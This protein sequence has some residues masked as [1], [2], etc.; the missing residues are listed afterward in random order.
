[1]N[2][3]LKQYKEAVLFYIAPLFSINT[4]DQ[5]Q[6][7]QCVEWLDSFKE[8]LTNYNAENYFN[9][10]YAY[11][12]QL[13]ARYSEAVS[14]QMTLWIA[15]IYNRYDDPILNEYNNYVTPKPDD[16]FAILSNQIEVVNERLHGQSLLTVVQA[17]MQVFAPFQQHIIE[18]L[19]NNP[20]DFLEELCST[21]N[22]AFN[23]QEKFEDI[24][25]NIPDLNEKDMLEMSNAVSDVVA[26]YVKVGQYASDLLVNLIMSDIQPHLDEYL[27]QQAWMEGSVDPLGNAIETIND[28]LGDLKEWISCPYYVGYI[29]KECFLKLV[30]IIFVL[31]YTF[32]LLVILLYLRSAK[33]G[34]NKR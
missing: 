30:Y 4:L 23:L 14:E 21:V 27:F 11:R 6:V 2:L 13:M 24:P 20:T 31:F 34:M 28:Y 26:E 22:D 16:T 9:E 19:K 17:C 8:E 15:N 1:M 25:Y 7:L 18:E 29:V 10:F 33:D 5:G 3:F 32:R 12:T